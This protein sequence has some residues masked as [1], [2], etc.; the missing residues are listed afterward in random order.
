ML[1][2][3]ILLF[4]CQFL[5]LEQ[6]TLLFKVITLLVYAL[7]SPLLGQNEVVQSHGHPLEKRGTCRKVS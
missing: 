7:D 6:C 5:H 3:H 1:H 4:E 2:R